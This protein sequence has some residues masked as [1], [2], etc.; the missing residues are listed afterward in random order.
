M[1][2]NIK[3]IEGLEPWEVMKRASEGEAVAEYRAQV[4]GLNE[5]SPE[6]DVYQEAGWYK[7]DTPLWRWNTNKY[8]IIDT[9]TPEIDFDEFYWDFFGL[10]GGVLLA[11][12]GVQIGAETLWS[13]TDNITILES[14]FY[15][16]PGG[17]QPVPDNVE[18][19]VVFL[20]MDSGGRDL[21][22]HAAKDVDW[23]GF[24]LIAFKL[25]GRVF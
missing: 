15:Y 2:K 5:S 12:D 17:E 4:I 25:T 10:Y 11:K 13:N 22:I 24:N 6:P 14:P 23:R 16:W 7:V 18:V 8:A 9:T 21:E 20:L 19:E 1:S 3:V